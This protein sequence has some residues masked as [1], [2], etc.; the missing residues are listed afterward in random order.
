MFRTTMNHP[1]Q[2]TIKLSWS[3]KRALIY[4][5]HVFISTFWCSIQRGG[6]TCFMFFA[7]PGRLVIDVAL[8]QTPVSGHLSFLAHLASRRVWC[9][10]CICWW[11]G[12]MVQKS[13]GQPPGMHKTV[14]IMGYLPYQLVRKW[15]ELSQ[16]L[17]TFIQPRWLALGFLKHQLAA[18]YTSNIFVSFHQ[19]PRSLFK[20]YTQ[21]WNQ[22]TLNLKVENVGRRSGFRP[23]FRTYCWC[24]RNPK[25]PPGTVPPY[26]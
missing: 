8:P 5:I 17:Q 19:V 11:Y 21:N 7:L 23:I 26:Q 12:L 24:F 4:S 16:Y 14:K 13:R 9:I 6:A 15:L 22:W 25:Q 18:R 20:N 3:S 10:S 2:R 1:F